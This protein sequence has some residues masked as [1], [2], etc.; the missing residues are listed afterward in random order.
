MRTTEITVQATEH[1]SAHEAVQHLEA[2]GDDHAIMVGDKYLT[3]KRAEVDR[4]AAAGIEFAY[5]FDYHGQI[6]AVPVN[7]R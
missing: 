1:P 6:M 4:I 5:L 3:L 2:S 7:H